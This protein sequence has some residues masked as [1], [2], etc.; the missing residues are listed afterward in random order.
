MRAWQLLIAL[1]FV[2]SAAVGADPL[3][4]RS[5]DG[6]LELVFTGAAEGRLGYSL[7]PTAGR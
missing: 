5:P 7:A 6:K 1:S 2:A 3:T 4:V